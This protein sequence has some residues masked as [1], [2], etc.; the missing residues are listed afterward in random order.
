MSLQSKFRW[1][2]D[3]PGNIVSLCPNCH[4][5]IHHANKADKH[6]LIEKL[7]SLR[8]QALIDF[9]IDIPIY[10]LLVAYK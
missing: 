4:R 3:V 7:Y 1:S 6:L 10:E 8:K 2:L 5:M 9:G